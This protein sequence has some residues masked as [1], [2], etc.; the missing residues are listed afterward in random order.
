VNHKAIVIALSIA[1]VGTLALLGYAVTKPQANTKI[2][3][4]PLAATLRLDGNKKT[5]AGTLYLTPGKHTIEASQEGF[6]SIKQTF[7][8]TNNK[9]ISLLFLLEPNSDTGNQYL[10]NHKSE[11]TEREALGGKQFNDVTAKIREIYPITKLLPHSG[12]SFTV[13]YGASRRQP[14][15]PYAI[16]LYVTVPAVGQET[17]AKNWI[18]YAGYK[19][20]D[21]EIIYQYQNAQD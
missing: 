4:S 19:L 14:N 16:A 11:Q 5:S 3:V 1:F 7:A 8:V 15:N 10:S 12:E 13:D 20:S 2:T 9:P 21:Y 17:R 18:T 6:K